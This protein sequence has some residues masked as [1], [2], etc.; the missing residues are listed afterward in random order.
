VLKR[1]GLMML[2]MLLSATS[3]ATQQFSR[4]QCQQL[5]QQRKDIRQQLRQPYTA[6]QGQQL[7]AQEQALLRLLQRHCQQPRPE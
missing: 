6:E 7:Q 4:E 1:Y 5:N 3:F 2:F